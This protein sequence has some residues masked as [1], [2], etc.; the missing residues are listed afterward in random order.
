MVKLRD[1]IASFWRK[2]DKTDE[3]WLWTGA[4]G[5]NGYG[6][7]RRGPGLTSPHRY[8][9]KITHGAEIPS[10]FV[11]DH[12]CRTRLCVRPEHLEAVTPTE[13]NRRA[14]ALRRTI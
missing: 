8:A 4:T 14:W 1:P 12:L 7:I 13:N 3:C 9:W 6:I 11:I 10:G 5:S 2:V